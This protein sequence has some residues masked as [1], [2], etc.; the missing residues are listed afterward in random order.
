[1]EGGIG[2]TY[3]GNLPNDNSGILRYV[4][5]EFPGIPLST[6]A[7]S[8]VNGLSLYGVGAG[9]TIEY[10]Q[11][12]SSGDD[13]FEWFGGNVNASLLVAN[14]NND[15]DFDTDLGSRAGCSLP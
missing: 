14:A 2:T 13:A 7:N 9:T 8:E 5:I 4:R 3:G 1:V 12:H 6:A 10:V 11:V 15:D